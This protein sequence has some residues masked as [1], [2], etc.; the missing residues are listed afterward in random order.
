MVVV[1]L[2]PRVRQSAR[3]RASPRE[4]ARVRAL[5]IHPQSAPVRAQS[6]YSAL[7]ARPRRAL[8]SARRGIYG[9]LVLIARNFRIERSFSVGVLAQTGGV[10]VNSTPKAGFMHNLRRTS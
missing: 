5:G 8:R 7:P 1:W 10:L 3:V 6:A 9:G 4:S 2:A